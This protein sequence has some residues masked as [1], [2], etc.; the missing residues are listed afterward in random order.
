MKNVAMMLDVWLGIRRASSRSGWTTSSQRLTA[1]QLKY[2]RN[3]A[4]KQLTTF[5]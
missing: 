1:W 5:S 3:M 2:Q 4:R